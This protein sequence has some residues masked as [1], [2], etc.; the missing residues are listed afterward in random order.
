MTCLSC[1]RRPPSER[2]LVPRAGTG[3]RV[4]RRAGRS[5]V[6]GGGGEFSLCKASGNGAGVVSSI[7]P[8]GRVIHPDE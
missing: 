4:L 8:S 2:G 6:E 1:T 7:Q 5:L 3:Q